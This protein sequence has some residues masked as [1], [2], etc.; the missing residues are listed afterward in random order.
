MQYIPVDQID[1]SSYSAEELARISELAERQVQAKKEEQIVELR[2]R[3]EELARSMGVSVNEVVEMMG[4]RGGV[5]VARK[6][7]GRAKIKYRHPHNSDL[8][9]TGRGHRPR[10]LSEALE[11]GSR[12]EDFMVE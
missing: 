6:S 3:A 12:L 7:P 10:W 2:R 11:Q 5:S 9:W 8:T 1:F 4:A